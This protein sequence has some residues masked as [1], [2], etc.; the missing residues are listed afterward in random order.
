MIETHVDAT[1]GGKAGA[2]AVAANETATYISKKSTEE[3]E[4]DKSETEVGEES[5]VEY[6]DGV[7]VHVPQK[8]KTITMNNN[9]T[10]AMKNN[11][12]VAIKGSET[13]G[14]KCG[15]CKG[16]IVVERLGHGQLRP[17]D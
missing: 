14:V 3:P 9:A 17:R 2:V 6:T 12:T 10:I 4:N 13:A 8:N 11:E 1:G 16:F 5:A 7:Q 15:G